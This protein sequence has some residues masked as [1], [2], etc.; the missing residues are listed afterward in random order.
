M[1][2]TE[3]RRK[4]NLVTGL[5]ERD[6]IPLFVARWMKIRSKPRGPY[7]SE[8]AFI[9]ALD[10][11]A[12]SYHHHSHVKTFDPV[13]A[14]KTRLRAPQCEMLNGGIGVVRYF[15]CLGRVD[16][17]RAQLDRQIEKVRKFLEKQQHVVRGL[18]VDVRGHSGGDI[19]PL[20]GMR[21]L[22]GDAVTFAWSNAPESVA[23]G[24]QWN[25]WQ[26]SETGRFTTG[27]LAFRGPI[28]LLFGRR[29]G[30][31]G[32][33]AAA[34]LWGKPTV[35]SF[36]ENSSGSLSGNNVIPIGGGAELIL[37][38]VMVTTSDGT[39]HSDELLRPD[40]L[41]ATPMRD[42]VRWILSVKKT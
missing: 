31:A 24:T 21:S 22:F 29:T 19:Y 36:G 11:Y 12:S 30:S 6:G 25:T 41:T 13:K 34:M 16:T 32:E 7:A 38:E 8:R 2:T 15:T 35:R 40:V 4:L 28:A 23:R 3:Q 33:A 1:S 10:V 17:H 20:Q 14:K 26:L 42:A 37:T 5:I 27:D 9:K 39:F 18:I